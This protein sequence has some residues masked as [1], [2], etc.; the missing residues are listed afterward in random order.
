MTNEG[1]R[2]PEAFEFFGKFL[3]FNNLSSWKKSTFTSGIAGPQGCLLSV[4]HDLTTF[5]SRHRRRLHETYRIDKRLASLIE[6]SYLRYRIGLTESTRPSAIRR[7]QYATIVT[8][9]D[10]FS[11]ND[12]AIWGKTRALPAMC[13]FSRKCRIPRWVRSGKPDIGLEVGVWEGLQE[14][15]VGPQGLSF[16]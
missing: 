12:S 10:P 11:M 16:A 2:N 3:L 9:N 7:D 15:A 8:C 6:Y 13:A 5:A 14:A 4:P 1:L